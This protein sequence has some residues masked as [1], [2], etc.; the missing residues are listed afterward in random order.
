VFVEAI[1]SGLSLCEVGDPFGPHDSGSQARMQQ[2]DVS[3]LRT[4]PL[5]ERRRDTLL[6][7]ARHSEQAELMAEVATRMARAPSFSAS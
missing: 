4:L 7:D 2:P 3:L 5:Q 1:E 6:G